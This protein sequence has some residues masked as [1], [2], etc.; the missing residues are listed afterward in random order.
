MGRGNMNGLIL[1]QIGDTATTGKESVAT[2][3]PAG[4]LQIDLSCFNR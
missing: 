1:H 2:K 3:L 4:A